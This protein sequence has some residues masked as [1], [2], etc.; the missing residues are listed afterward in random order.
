MACLPGENSIQKCHFMLLI[1]LVHIA[2]NEYKPMRGL[3]FHNEQK[4]LT[5]L[6]K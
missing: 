5:L 2:D 1:F 4:Y 3:A 6:S